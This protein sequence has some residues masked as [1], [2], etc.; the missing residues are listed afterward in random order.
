MKWRSTCHH[1]CPEEREERCWAYNTD[2]TICGQPA[3]AVDQVRG[4]WVCEKHRNQS[5]LSLRLEGAGFK[6]VSA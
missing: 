5:I 3:T 1:G 2:G 4:F 6:E